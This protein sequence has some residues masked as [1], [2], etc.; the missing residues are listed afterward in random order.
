MGD[1]A[2]SQALTDELVTIVETCREKV[3]VVFDEHVAKLHAAKALLDGTA[4]KLSDERESQGRTE[5]EQGK[6][7]ADQ[8]KVLVGFLR[9]ISDTTLAR[10]GVVRPLTP[11]DS[12]YSFGT[13]ESLVMPAAVSTLDGP[14]DR[15]MTAKELRKEARWERRGSAKTAAWVDATAGVAQNGA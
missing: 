5:A 6:M 7:S 15:E 13:N 9:T 11:N 3:M 4:S 10:A 14:A 2:C 12:E 8:Q 1:A